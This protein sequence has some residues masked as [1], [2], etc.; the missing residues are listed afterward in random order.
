MKS[1]HVFPSA[2][3]A[4]RCA[5][6]AAA[7]ALAQGCAQATVTEVF[8]GP[9]G[10][11]FTLT[12]A[13][14]AVLVGFEARAGAWVDAVGIICAP[15]NPADRRPTTQRAVGGWAGGKGGAHQEDYCGDGEAVTGIALA[16]TRGHDLP[17]QYVNTVA[18]LCQGRP[19]AD[20][21][22][23]SGEGC[24]PIAPVMRGYMSPFQS[25]KRYQYDQIRCPQGEVAVGITGRSGQFM[26]AMGLV[27]RAPLGH[28]VLGR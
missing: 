1:I 21:C 15:V 2:R 17:R 16:H 11:P 9:G 8:G 25:E 24:G 19:R 27:C 12:C 28:P 13:N 10:G 18:L 6:F 20:R 14:N 3:R 23:S 5:G 4:F 26:D 22:I 7:L